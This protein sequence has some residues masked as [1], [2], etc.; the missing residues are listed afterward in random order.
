MGEE[1]QVPLK[2]SL[3]S[4]VKRNNV[5]PFNTWRTILEADV[6]V[7][8]FLPWTPPTKYTPTHSEE[9]ALRVLVS[10]HHVSVWLIFSLPFFILPC[11]LSFPLSCYTYTATDPSP[12]LP[13]C[14]SGVYAKPHHP[15]EQAEV[16]ASVPRDKAVPSPAAFVEFPVTPLSFPVGH[17]RCATFFSLLCVLTAFLLGFIRD[18]RSY[19]HRSFG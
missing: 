14:P 18:W 4:R 16:P 13:P 11:S 10:H 6:W 5:R 15:L 3:P 19:V 17:A 9:G 7:S 2:T 12:N 1:H 8:L